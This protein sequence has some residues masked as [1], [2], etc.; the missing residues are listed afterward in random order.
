MILALALLALF[1]PPQTSDATLPPA[2]AHVRYTVEGHGVQIYNCTAQNGGF[3][4]VFKEPA[5]ELFDPSTHQ[6][7]GMHTAGPTWTWSDG[8]A[9]VGKVL[10]TNPSDNPANILWLLLETHPAGTTTGAL[11]N[12]TLVRRSNTQAGKA[13]ATGC[14]AK[15]VNVVL[16]VPYTA[17]Y[18]FYSTK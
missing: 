13:P 18:T 1:A 4:W 15:N 10:Q 11:S 5:A 9:I 8:S 2:T 6:Q 3:Q 14:D 12:I 16:R 17:T 7:V